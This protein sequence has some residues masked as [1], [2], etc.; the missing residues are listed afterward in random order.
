M[1]EDLKKFQMDLTRF[2]EVVVPENHEKLMKKITLKLYDELTGD[3]PGTPKDTGWHRANWGV[4]IGLGTPPTTPVGVYPEEKR[5][6]YQPM[7]RDKYFKVENIL[8]ITPL[9][10]SPFIWLYNNAPGIMVL[11]NGHSKQAPTGM[12]VNALNVVQTEINNL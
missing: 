7:P 5:G 11:E 6:L 2:R 4:K 10:K 3:N 12:L 8:S 1:I 9:G